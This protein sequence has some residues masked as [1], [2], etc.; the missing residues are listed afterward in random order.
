MPSFTVLTFRHFCATIWTA[1]FSTWASDEALKVRFDKRSILASSS[2]SRPDWFFFVPQGCI[3]TMG[4]RGDVKLLRIWI[5][6]SEFRNC[7]FGSK[8]GSGSLLFCEQISC[9][10]KEGINTLHHP[11]HLFRGL[12]DSKVA[13]S[14]AAGYPAKISSQICTNLSFYLNFE[15]FQFFLRSNIQ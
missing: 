10:H 4:G 1:R 6:E 2:G 14:P 9:T 7:G 12:M 13:K 5:H 15:F 8:C 3:F 11:K